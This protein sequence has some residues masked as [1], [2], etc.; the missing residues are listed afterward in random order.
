VLDPRVCECCSTAA[1]E[2]PDGVIVVYRGRT[3]DEIRDIHVVRYAG[4][5]W[6]KPTVVHDDNWKIDACPIN[7]PAIS[8]NGR[9]VAI[10][11]FTGVNDQGRAFVAFSHDAG[12]TFAQPI[13]VDDARSL[14]RLGVEM[15]PDGSAAV[16][17]I[18]S[19]DHAQFRVRRISPQGVRSAPVTI[20]E[21][22]GGRYPRMAHYRDE[23]LFSWTELKNG[24][25]LVK[26]A[27]TSLR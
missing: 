20:A 17:Y 14:G 9:E 18:E 6:S 3:K 21:T 26:T 16:T 12:S 4:G 15:L 5:S 19:G 7:G 8:A 25:S 27:R 23:L 2:I 22:S 1:A 24:A 10:A 11:W 13:R